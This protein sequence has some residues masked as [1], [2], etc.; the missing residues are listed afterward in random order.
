MGNQCKRAIK[1]KLLETRGWDA[2]T[3]AGKRIVEG[4]VSLAKPNHKLMVN[5]F[6]NPVLLLQ[7][8]D[9]F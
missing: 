5:N 4:I 9:F 7:R 2:E 6:S 3:Y 8:F 1:D